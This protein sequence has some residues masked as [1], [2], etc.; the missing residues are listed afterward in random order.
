MV[1]HSVEVESVPKLCGRHAPQFIPQGSAAK[2]ISGSASDLS[3]AGPTKS[4]VETAVL[5]QPVDLVQ[6][7]GNLLNL[8]HDD[9]LQDLEE[10]AQRN[11]RS[12]PC[13]PVGSIN[14]G[15][16]DAF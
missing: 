10:P 8:V 6:Q 14:S 7:G 3:S 13:K 15:V 2:Q 5:H 4:E 12:C 16:D 11:E 9:L 1:E